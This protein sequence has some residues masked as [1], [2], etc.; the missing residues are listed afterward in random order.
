M[1]G[2]CDLEERDVI[3]ETY[4]EDFS[5]KAI[6]NHTTS[7]S[8]RHANVWLADS[9]TRAIAADRGRFRRPVRSG[10]WDTRGRLKHIFEA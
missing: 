8:C 4:V 3:F 6:V 9:Q 10:G 5:A 1:A 7:V 2:P